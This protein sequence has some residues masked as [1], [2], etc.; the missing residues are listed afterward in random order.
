M[1]NIFSY[2]NKNKVVVGIFSDPN[3]LAVNLLEGLLSKFCFVKIFTNEV[4]DWQ[5]K[6][7]H[8][9]NQG[10]FEILNS[11]EL[12]NFAIELNYCV[13]IFGFINS[14]EI[15]SKISKL[16]AAKTFLS[17]KTLVVLPREKSTLRLGLS[18]HLT[19][20]DLG[21]IYLG[22]L[23]GA[24]FD[25]Q[26]NLLLPSVFRK[27]FTEGVMKIEKD[28][29][30]YPLFVA[31]ASQTLI[32]WIFSFG[33]YG[34]K[35]FLL[36]SALSVNGLYGELKRF[37]PNLSINFIKGKE[38]SQLNDFQNT[39]ILPSRTQYLLTETLGW[40][41]KNMPSKLE[42]KKKKTKPTK[43]KEKRTKTPL[44][45]FSFIGKY[46]NKLP[47]IKRSFV[48]LSILFVLLISP[49]LLI[50]AS[51]IS[52]YG[53]YGFI[54]RGDLKRAEFFAKLAK[55]PAYVAL[56]ES[57]FF[58]NIPVVKTIYKEADTDASIVLSAADIAIRGVSLAS[59]GAALVNNILGN[60]IYDSQPL[61]ERIIL[62]LDYIFKQSSFLQ[63][64][65][66]SSFIYEKY[67]VDPINKKLNLERLKLFALEGQSIVKRLPQ[68]L[69]VDQKKTY[70]IL[71][72]NNMEL[73]PTGGFIGSFALVSLDGGKISE[74]GVSD[75][76]SADGQLK[77]HVEPPEP[78]KKYLGE[79]NWYL[80]DSN[81][82][83]DFAISAQRAEWF[84]DKEIDREVDGVIGVDLQ[85]AK[86]LLDQIG[87]VY[88]SDFETTLTSENLY[89]KTQSEVEDEFFPGSYKKTSFLTS[90]AR[91]I[92][93]DL[94]DSNLQ[95]KLGI[96]RVVARGLEERHFQVF[97]HD[98]KLQQS[99]SSLNWDGGLPTNECGEYCF[100][101]FIGVVE[102]NV[103]VNKANYYIQREATLDIF[104]EPG[105]VRKI[106]SV[107][108]KNSANPQLGS[109][110]RYKVYLRVVAGPTTETIGVNEIVGEST[111]NLPFELTRN[112]NKVEVGVIN[113]IQP[114]ES[115]KFVFNLKSK[116]S[117]K[118][119]AGEEYNLYI[120][121]QA[122]VEGY[123]FEIT[124]HP[125]QKTPINTLPK[126]SLTQEG[127]YIYNTVLTRDFASRVSW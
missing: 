10:S 108:I 83:P 24:R 97:V 105:E 8:I 125:V 69:G 114:G 25:I 28:L 30:L 45:A 51:S 85:F 79:A 21:I 20:E 15:K 33:P 126:F 16:K 46:S 72:Q 118:Y 56:Y 55:P 37:Y 89:E 91:Q 31:D 54:S 120:R 80:R 92:L 116:N 70:L 104:L 101:D 4:A 59:S 73:R 95:T 65:L 38:S 77:G 35:A 117:L 112:S 47:N 74:I 122:G 26:S 6:T 88:L 29:I 18:K 23:L 17:T 34:K 50:L 106:L 9:S 7:S 100:A 67:L 13:C 107:N 41:S 93:T 110:G 86:T 90:L 2:Q 57:R 40:L 58:E 68:S 109:S 124:F 113:E 22:D 81:W 66:E 5:E 64:E 39:T 52:L 11:H 27:I 87:P 62:D 115:K 43:K 61:S 48:F 98:G 123:P 14:D 102:A 19:S 32:R 78:I 103:G 76:Y 99:I 42:L 121:K 60:E 44:V 63:G 3:F 111:Q 82:D 96:I 36:G 53:F 71:L 75:V 1:T 12:K 49:W 119:I 84:L 94:P 127:A